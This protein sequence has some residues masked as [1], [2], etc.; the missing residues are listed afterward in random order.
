MNTELKNRSGLSLQDLEEV[1]DALAHAI[2]NIGPQKAPL[3]LT[4]LALLCA[5]ELGDS[6]LFQKQLKIASIDLE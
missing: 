1:Y 2:D 5:H 4:K 3:M 6:K